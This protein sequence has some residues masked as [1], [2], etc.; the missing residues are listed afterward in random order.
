[1]DRVG[2][3]ESTFN[4]DF[5]FGKSTRYRYHQKDKRTVHQFDF[6]VQVRFG[7][8]GDNLTFKSIANGQEAGSANIKFD[9]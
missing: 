3:V 4:A 2:I 5:D 1:M 9:R 8:K 7:N 6:D